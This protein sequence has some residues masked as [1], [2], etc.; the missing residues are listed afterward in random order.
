MRDT[1]EVFKPSGPRMMK[2]ELLNRREARGPH[3]H[4]RFS[5]HNDNYGNKSCLAAGECL[6]K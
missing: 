2:R 6:R 1:V 5:Q 3:R 4:C